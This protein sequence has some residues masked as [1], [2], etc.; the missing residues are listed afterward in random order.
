MPNSPQ[1]DCASPEYE[2]RDDVKAVNFLFSGIVPRLA[3][4]EDNRIEQHLHNWADHHRIPPRFYVG[5]ADF[6][7]S[8]VIPHCQVF[9]RFLEPHGTTMIPDFR[10]YEI[11]TDARWDCAVLKTFHGDRMNTLLVWRGE[12]SLA[13]TATAWA[14]HPPV[15]P[16]PCSV[17]YHYRLQSGAGGKV[18]GPVSFEILCDLAAFSQLNPANQ[19]KRG[20]NDRWVEAHEIPGL[21]FYKRTRECKIWDCKHRWITR[22]EPREK[23]PKCGA[24]YSRMIH[25]TNVK[26]KNAP[27]P[28]VGENV[29]VAF[30]RT[31]NFNSKFQP[32]D[33]SS[34]GLVLGGNKIM[35][36][37]IARIEHDCGGSIHEVGIGECRIPV[38]IELPCKQILVGWRHDSYQLLRTYPVLK[39]WWQF[40]R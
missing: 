5:K 23:C 21:L 40:W 31:W 39:K 30:S 38:N 36:D 17:L 24:A 13:V 34:S 19:V 28:V 27:H 35:Q 6:I 33:E 26:V 29:W 3:K 12:K 32:V 15:P 11:G 18:H 4:L 9:L 7:K 37:G 2:T 14:H 10:K 16:T 1:P 25:R 22:N 20:T 8:L